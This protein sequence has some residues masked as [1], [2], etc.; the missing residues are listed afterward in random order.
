MMNLIEGRPML[1]TIPKCCE[2]YFRE[3]TKEWPAKT[4][5]K[6]T[7]K[8]SLV[9]ISPYGS[10]KFYG[11]LTLFCRMQDESIK[12]LTQFQGTSSHQKSLVMLEAGQ[13]GTTPPK[14]VFLC[15][16]SKG[17]PLSTKCF[18]IITSRDI[19]HFLEDYTSV[20]APILRN[21]FSLGNGKEFC[22]EGE[23]LPS[24]SK[25]LLTYLE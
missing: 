6:C 8:S 11:K 22:M 19:Q 12:E 25:P 1:H 17:L 14:V 9:F 13:N 3:C 2:A 15:T 20:R 5:A 7:L 16:S 21:I 4:L 18:T 24:N 23:I 10:L